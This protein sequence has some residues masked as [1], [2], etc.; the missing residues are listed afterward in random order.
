M[1][2]YWVIN[3]IRHQLKKENIHSGWKEVV[4]IMNTQKAVTTTAQND[5]DEIIHIRRSSEPSE[6]ARMLYDGVKYKYVP[7]TK[8]KSVVLKLELR[9]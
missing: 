1:L 7:Y 9:E 2:A 3:T 6:K 4:R 8:K 5:K